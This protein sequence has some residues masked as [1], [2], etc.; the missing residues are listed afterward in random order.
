M[1]QHFKK[2]GI[3][4]LVLGIGLCQGAIPAAVWAE[5]ASST[6]TVTSN[7][8]LTDDIRAAIKDLAAVPTAN[9]TQ[10]SAV[11]RVYN[12]GTS[13]KRLPEHELRVRTSSGVQYTL[14]ASAANKGALEPREISELT[15][16]ANIDTKDIGEIVDASFVNVDVYSYP[17]VE[18]T[19]MTMAASSVWYGASS[20]IQPQAL[21]WGK[22]FTIPN[23]N[24]DVIYTPVDASYQNTSTGRTALIT[25]LA[26]NPNSSQVQL[27][28]FRLDAQGG[29]T[30]YEG[31][32]METTPIKL[33]G[34]E[35]KYVHFAVPVEAATD[36]SKL[37]VVALDNYVS[38]T[39]T[40]TS[41]S[42]GKLAVAWPTEDQLHSAAQSYTFGQPIAFDPLTKLVDKTTE[43]SLIELHVSD[44]PGEGYKSAIAKFKITNNSDQPVATPEFQAEL[45]NAG[46]TVYKGERQ[47]A[48][49][50]N[51]NPKLSYVVSYTFIMPESEDTANYTL[52]LLDSKTVAPY[53]AKI[54]SVQAA[55]QETEE[56][57]TF[58]LY[59]F[60]IKFNDVSASFLYSSGVYTVKFR[61][62]LD[63]TQAEN[64]VADSN[65]SKVRLE[66]VDKTGRV[67]S[68]QDLALSGTSK[69]TSGV[70][71]YEN[72]IKMDQLNYPYKIN[73]YELVETASGTA[74]R[75]LT[76]VNN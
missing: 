17:K 33:E 70:Q 4:T 49:A 50:S 3:L 56:G 31:K 38:K 46:G 66:L 26:Y 30:T 51:V 47:T 53:T 13:T 44:N 19:L 29:L 69:L 22:D 36:I 73:V 52:N 58:Q 61:L 5:N 15:Y 28:S 7:Y 11:I 14:T 63:I 42:T 32:I 67:V 23:V 39:G 10:I 27:P 57:N 34:G 12:G 75:L 76:T 59:P 64:V 65:A 55:K 20:S 40:A 9:G 74:K 45:R 24:S 48:V 62:A 16:M 43:V 68:Y 41:L 18:T 25:L 2:T 72:S 21:E 60:T 6:P 35:K 37:F 8:G 1:K 71:Y 54:A